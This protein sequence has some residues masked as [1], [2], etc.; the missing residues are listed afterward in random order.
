MGRVSE[1]LT[2]LRDDRLLPSL[3]LGPED[4]RALARFAARFCG[5][6]ARSFVIL[7]CSDIESLVF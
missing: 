4:L 1:C 6:M 7:N 3:D 2:E 5:L